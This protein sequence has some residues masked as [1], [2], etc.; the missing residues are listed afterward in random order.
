MYGVITREGTGGGG[1]EGKGNMRHLT[2]SSSSYKGMKGYK[3]GI[4][5]VPGQILG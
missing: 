2:Q 5:V 3:I 1:G 4:Y